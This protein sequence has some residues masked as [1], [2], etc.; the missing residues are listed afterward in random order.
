MKSGTGWSVWPWPEGSAS[1]KAFERARIEA[2]THFGAPSN[3]L[4]GSLGAD[5]G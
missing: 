2:K 5:R 3:E 4:V 1:I